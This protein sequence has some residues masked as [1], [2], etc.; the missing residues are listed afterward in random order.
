MIGK[1]KSPRAPIAAPIFSEKN[2]ASP[3]AGP[4]TK[5]LTVFIKSSNA[6]DNLFILF[7]S[8]SIIALIAANLVST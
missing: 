8:G 5:V 6:L 3:S 1:V 2:T 7:V 4:A